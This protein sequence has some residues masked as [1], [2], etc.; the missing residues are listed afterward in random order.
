MLQDE[1][2]LALNDIEKGIAEGLIRELS[3]GDI[4]VKGRDAKVAVTYEY[5]STKNEKIV[6]GIMLG[7]PYKLRYR[8]SNRI[9]FSA[10]NCKDVCSVF[11]DVMAII[12]MLDKKNIYDPD[13]SWPVDVDLH[14]ERYV[15]FAV[16][17]AASFVSIVDQI[18]QEGD[19]ASYNSQYILSVFDESDECIYDAL[20]QR[21]KTE[22]FSKIQILQIWIRG[23]ILYY[24]IADG[25]VL[26]PEHQRSLTSKEERDLI[27]KIYKSVNDKFHLV[28]FTP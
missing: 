12:H 17:V 10:W 25:A 3:A 11:Y 1:S 2:I 5:Y 26:R 22:G 4:P 16:N 23:E 28:E 9:F 24:A 8:D 21:F 27:R 15:F 14:T 6:R 18:S 19:K 7:C 13:V 20:I